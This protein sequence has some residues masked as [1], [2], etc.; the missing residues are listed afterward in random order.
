MQV[1]RALGIPLAAEAAG[2]VGA[3]VRAVGGRLICIVYLYIHLRWAP[4]VVA[5]SGHV[6]TTV[7]SHFVP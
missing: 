5:R 6:A 1:Q 2:G 7:A 4:R 3:D